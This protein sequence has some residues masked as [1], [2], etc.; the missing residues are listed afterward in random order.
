MYRNES[1]YIVHVYVHV[2]CIREVHVHCIHACAIHVHAYTSVS[3]TT[4]Q[5]FSSSVDLEE[6]R[7]FADTNVTVPTYTCTHDMYMCVRTWT[8]P[9]HIIL[10][11]G[12]IIFPSQIL[13]K[14]HKYTLLG[15][16]GID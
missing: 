3:G 9:F 12:T 14:T 4:H 7:Q 10:I 5:Y 11:L 2:T 15:Q 16:D 6:H 8:S 1:I 13:Q